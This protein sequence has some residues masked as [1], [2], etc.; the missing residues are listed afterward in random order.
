MKY[1]ILAIFII[2]LTSCKNSS[3]NEKQSD[4][5]IIFSDDLSYV[6]IYYHDQF[7]NDKTQNI[8]SEA[9]NY[10]K[11]KEF[12]KAKEKLLQAY[13]IEPNNIS[14]SSDLGNIAKYNSEYEL[15]VKYFYK[16]INNSTSFN[17]NATLNLGSTYFYMGEYQKSIARLKNV[18]KNSNDT[19]L[20]ASAFYIMTKSYAE[21]RNCDDSKASLKE[22]KKLTQNNN[23]FQVMTSELETFALN[24]GN[25][26]F[27]QNI[28]L[29][30]NNEKYDFQL[31]TFSTTDSI[32]IQN[33]PSSL[34]S[35]VTDLVI[36][37]NSTTIR[38]RIEKNEFEEFLYRDFFANSYI[39]QTKVLKVSAKTI[40]IISRLNNIDSE[41]YCMIGYTMN[42][43]KDKLQSIN[44]GKVEYF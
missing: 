21:F 19:I 31:I 14:I 2:T 36:S 4:R 25:N 8:Y 24:C 7:E 38:K 26:N 23:K 32:N 1:F 30:S 44:L 18:L 17:S 6:D 29:Q 20:R 28:S 15:A 16:A 34:Y 9:I 43:E 39:K 5:E 35:R 3:S 41:K 22:F 42:I 33:N 40:F 12:K 10:I 37:T 13:E 27:K 11:N